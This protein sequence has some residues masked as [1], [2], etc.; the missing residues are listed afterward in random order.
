[1]QEV[2]V[3][4][5]VEALEVV[6]VD[7]RVAGEVVEVSE[8]AQP[9]PAGVGDLEEAILEGA[10]RR[11]RLAHQR[12]DVVEHVHHQVDGRVHRLVEQLVPA[13]DQRL[14]FGKSHQAGNDPVDQRVARAEAR[15]QVEHRDQRHL[16]GLED[17]ALDRLERCGGVGG[18][19]VHGR[20]VGR[21]A[22]PGV[23]PCVA[24]AARAGDRLVP[25]RSG[26]IGGAADILPDRPRRRIRRRQVVGVELDLG[27]ETLDR[28][29]DSERVTELCVDG[30]AGPDPTAVGRAGRVG[31]D[32][33][34]VAELP[35]RRADR[36]DGGTQRVDLGD[37][38]V[39][40]R[41][42]VALVEFRVVA[43]EQL[44]DRDERVG[45]RDVDVVAVRD[46]GV[47]RLLHLLA[48]ELEQLEHEAQRLG[49][50]T[51]LRHQRA[52]LLARVAGRREHRVGLGAELEGAALELC[53][54]AVDGG[55]R[56]ADL[57]DELGEQR[58]D[59]PLRLLELGPRAEQ[60]ALDAA[61]RDQRRR[62]R[63]RQRRQRGGR[64]RMGLACWAAIT[65]GTPTPAGNGGGSGRLL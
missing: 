51:E 40:E 42:E 16:G 39:E 34:A 1:M 26:R 58:V 35:G 37:H 22:D 32:Q 60:V 27:D 13:R 8:T 4:H 18:E 59:V 33:H 44:V 9:E 5:H 11:E 57:H 21:T 61:E 43:V 14:G 49:Q 29:H 36:L 12:L 65:S 41:L 24:A 64:N 28:E 47:E 54:H 53:L 50:S 17:L 2:E 55:H 10:E 63:V 56:H 15:H 46:E 23:E 20:C 62:E 31:V 19:R 25:A 48:V 52:D 3:G 7:H 6:A 45:G 38:R 30:T